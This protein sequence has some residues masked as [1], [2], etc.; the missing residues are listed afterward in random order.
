MT[1]T[2]HPFE[3]EH[4]N[5]T[6]ARMFF[7]YEGRKQSSDRA[8]EVRLK[9][10]QLFDTQNR[11][12]N[13]FS[14]ETPASCARTWHTDGFVLRWSHVLGSGVTAQKQS[15]YYWRHELCT[16]VSEFGTFP[17]VQGADGQVLM[18]SGRR[19]ARLQAQRWL[20]LCGKPVVPKPSPNIPLF[21]QDGAGTGAEPVLPWC[22]LRT[23]PHF[24][25]FEK[26]YIVEVEMLPG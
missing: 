14:R 11:V 20:A 26:R 22:L 18:W 7:L 5:E 3:H 25:K 4:T 21:H 17:L 6:L 2:M 9:V 1:D 23:G 13:Q 15:T 8:R 10:T 12:S 24:D 19:T 16:S